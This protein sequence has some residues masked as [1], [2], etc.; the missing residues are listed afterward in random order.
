[1]EEEVEDKTIEEG[2]VSLKIVETMILVM[3]EE[4]TVEEM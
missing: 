1:M 2:K 3:L 4:E